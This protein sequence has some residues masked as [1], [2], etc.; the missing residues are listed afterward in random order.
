MTHK[1]PEFSGA[2]LLP[3]TVFFPGTGLPLRIF[4]ERYREMLDEA[5]ENDGV[6]CVG[7][8]V[9]GKYSTDKS[10][11]GSIGT[12]GLIRVSHE[13]E[14]GTSNLV[15]Q[16]IARVRFEEWLDTKSYPF[17]RIRPLPDT[18][19]T[20]EEEKA[21]KKR[22]RKAVDIY[23]RDFPP[24]YGVVFHQMMDEVDD[25]SSWCYLIAHQFMPDAAERQKMLEMSEVRQRVD[26]LAGILEDES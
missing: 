8:V 1:I 24:E 21:A 4:E 23:L 7:N 14:D 11:V 13:E 3:N 9:P 22:L 25:V 19:L 18:T 15:L 16:G 17:A 10:R 2:I 26:F 6:F 20:A 5:L 12:L